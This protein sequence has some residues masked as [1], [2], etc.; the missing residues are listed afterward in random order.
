M[1]GGAPEG[2]LSSEQVDALSSAAVVLLDR[3][4]SLIWVVQV[5]VSGGRSNRRP[6]YAD[7]PLLDLLIELDDHIDRTEALGRF[8][9][10]IQPVGKISGPGGPRKPFA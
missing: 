10:Q 5:E 6:G 9:G 8:I 1:I 7:Q 3:F 4:F 2:L